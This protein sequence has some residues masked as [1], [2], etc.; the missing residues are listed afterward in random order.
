MAAVGCDQS[1]GPQ[2]AESADGGV[3]GGRHQAGFWRIA[4][5]G[6]TAALLAAAVDECRSTWDA[7]TAPLDA[8][9]MSV[10]QWQVHIIAANQLVAGKITLNQANAYWERTRIQAARKIHRFHHADDAYQAGPQSCRPPDARGTSDASQAALTA[11]QASVAQRDDTLR[12]ARA[13]IDTWH[14][15]VTH[16]NLMPAGNRSPTRTAQ[17][18]NKYWKQGVA[19]LHRYRTQARQ[20]QNQRC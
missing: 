12:A 16:M 6:R 4:R 13:A 8:A 19:E 2:R 1:S 9:A 10:R 15:H 7:Q 14:H 18:W 3:A 5:I 11:C 20:I 17:R